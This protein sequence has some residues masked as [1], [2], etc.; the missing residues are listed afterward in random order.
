M[1]RPA[2]AATPA[3]I[4]KNA[5]LSMMV[6][7]L[8]SQPPMKLPTKLVS[9]PHAHHHRDHAAGRDLRHQ[10]KPD[11][12]E[13]ELAD[14]D[15]DEIGESHSQLACG[16]AAGLPDRADHD[17]VGERDAEAAERHLGHGRRLGAAR[18]LPRPQHQNERREREDHERIEGLEPGHRNL[19]VPDQQIDVTVGVVVGPERD[20]VALLLVGRPEQAGRAGT[21]RS[22]PG[23]RAI[24]SGRAAGARRPRSPT[25]SRSSAGS[26]GA[27]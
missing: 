8:P 14:G 6:Q 2:S 5:D 12:R 24:R 27:A 7:K 13:I 22:A 10:R 20:G 3:I 16:A 9:E 21:A 15:D 4:R 18:R 11:R 25:R 17:Q 1:T 19:A 26:V 23:S